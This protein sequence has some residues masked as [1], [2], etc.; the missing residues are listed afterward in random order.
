MCLRRRIATFSRLR[1]RHPCQLERTRRA[2]MSLSHLILCVYGLSR[3]CGPVAVSLLCNTLGTR[4][5]AATHS[6][7]RGLTERGIMIASNVI[8]DGNVIIH[9]PDLVNLYGCRIGEGSRIG[10][11]V[12]IQRN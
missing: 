8:L 3:S 11:F 10:T 6:T 4:T 1:G 9:H 7:Q 2:A 5:F 12:E